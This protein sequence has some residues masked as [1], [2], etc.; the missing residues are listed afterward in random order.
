MFKE[1][2]EAWSKTEVVTTDK[3]LTERRVFASAFPQAKL[4]LCLFHTLRSFSREVT[5]EKSGVRS[6]VRD[7]LLSI[8]NAMANACSEEVFEQQCALLEEMNVPSASRY[9]ERNWLHIKEEWV[10]CHKSQHF[11]LGEQT[12]NRLESLN[13]KIKSV[14]ARYASLDQFFTDFFCVLRVLRDE[15]S[16]ASVIARISRSAALAPALEEDAQLY[17]NILTPYACR[18]VMEQLTRRGKITLPAHGAPFMSSEGVLDVM[19]NSCN[20]AFRLTRSLPCRHIFAQRLADGQPAFD[21]SPVDD[22]WL[23]CHSQAVTE[24]PSDVAIRQLLPGPGPAPVTQKYRKGME[25]AADLAGLM[26]EVGTAEFRV[27]L[28]IL[29]RLRREWVT[30][31]S[32]QGKLQE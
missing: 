14:C 5:Q 4:H 23:A 31:G 21:A 30:T 26:S 15:R 7:T 1:H 19:G 3:D 11:T 2:N 18:A 27:R 25:V 8:F 28:A 12:N 13:G 22:W 9:F 16:H 20:C 32:H 6:G 10:A 17:R 24:A 29:E